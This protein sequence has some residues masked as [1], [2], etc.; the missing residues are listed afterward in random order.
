M[1]N[2]SKVSEFTLTALS[3]HPH[4]KYFLFMV[5]ILIYLMTLLINLLILYL[6]LTDAQLH[7]PM[8]FFLGNLAFLDMSYSSVTAPRMISDFIS[9]ST[10]IS[11]PACITQMFFFIYFAC[12]EIFLLAAMSYDRYVAVC[13]PLHYIQ[14][15]SWKVCTQMISVVWILGLLYSLAHMLCSLRLMFCDSTIINNFFCDLPN[16]LRLSC[17]DTF[18]NFMV[19]FVAGGG[20]GMVAFIITFLPYIQIISTVLKINNS[21]GKHKAFSTCTSHITVVSIFYG[22]IILIYFVPTTSY[23]FVLNSLLSVIYSVI[24]PFL[25]PLIYSLRNKDLISALK[26]FHTRFHNEV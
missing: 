23:L 12:T 11:Y 25:N 17:T 10:T 7:T 8:Y 18:I 9:K 16:L 2:I 19:S 6:F 24:N 21:D 5:F 4:I 26:K 1:E 20:L 13:H 3:H 15:M 14:I 22:S